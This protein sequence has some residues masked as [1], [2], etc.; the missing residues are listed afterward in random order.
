MLRLAPL[1]EICFYREHD[2]F[3]KNDL[4]LIKC[5]KAVRGCHVISV[6]IAT[7]NQKTLFY[8]EMLVQ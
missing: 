2:L 4:L 8:A 6:D 1:T 7:I 5:K 3:L